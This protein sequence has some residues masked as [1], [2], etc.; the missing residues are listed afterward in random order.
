ML[1]TDTA[2]CVCACVC[3]VG[4]WVGGWFGWV[5]VHVWCG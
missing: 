4:E 2:V 5:S 1:L 3:G